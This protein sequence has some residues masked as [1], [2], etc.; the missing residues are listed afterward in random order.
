MEAVTSALAIWISVA[1]I[2]VTLFTV[3]RAVCDRIRFTGGNT[4]STASS[5][6]GDGYQYPG[7]AFK[8]R[9]ITASF[10]APAPEAQRGS[11]TGGQRQCFIHH[12]IRRRP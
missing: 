5:D 11:I 12:P 4:T 7:R 2:A 6:D 1:A 3:T 8:R 10:T 9:L